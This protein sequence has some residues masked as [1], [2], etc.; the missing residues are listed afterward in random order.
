LK[1]EAEALKEIKSAIGMEGFF[2]LV[3]EKVFGQDIRRLLS[4]SDMWKSRTPP[5]PLDYREFTVPG[6]QRC[7]AM[8]AED[9]PIWDL[10]TNVAVFKYRSPS[11][12]KELITVWNA[13]RSDGRNSPKGK[14]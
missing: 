3:F 13:F 12:R 5:T 8:A 14:Y 7:A 11:I 4:M 1:K 2:A 9:Q 10:E 6:Q